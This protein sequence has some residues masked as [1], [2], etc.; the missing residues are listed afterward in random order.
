M[1]YEESASNEI[2]CASPLELAMTSIRAFIP[3]NLA[4]PPRAQTG[5]KLPLEDQFQ[6]EFY[7]AF[8]SVV[9][10]NVLVSPEYI[11]KDGKGGGAIDFLVPAKGWGFELTRN[12]SKIRE[13][14]ERFEPGGKYH[15]LI[16]SN[17]MKEHVVLDFTISTPK[18][19]HPGRYLSSPQL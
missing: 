9:D 1:L 10:G 17:V 11:A 2:R 18:K 3:R 8:Y 16:M 4:D 14:M 13:H 6:K 19:A 12:R 7:R 5:Q 15:G